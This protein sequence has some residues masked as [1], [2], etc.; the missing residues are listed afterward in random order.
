MAQRFPDDDDAFLAALSFVDEFSFDTESNP[1]TDHLLKPSESLKPVKWDLNEA[2][3]RRRRQ[4]NE[5]KKLLRRAGVYADPNRARSERRQEIARLREQLEQLQLDAQ[6]LR[7]RAGKRR[8][9]AEELS[10]S[11]GLLPQVPAVWQ[12]MALR[13][14]QRKEEAERENI[15]LKLVLKR[16]QQVAQ[17]LGDLVRRRAFQVTKECTDLTTQPRFRHHVVNVLD[18]D[19][20]MEDFR[21]L[22]LG[23]EAAYHEMEDVFAANGLSGSELSPLDIHLREGVDRRYIECFSH[24]VLPFELRATTAAVWEHFKGVEKHFGGG[25]IYT[26][27][28]K[29]LAEPYTV[30]ENFTKELYSNTSR[31]DI[32][33]KQVV[34]RYVEH[35]H[36]VVVWLAHVAPTN[37]AQDAPRT[38]VYSTWLH[39]HDTIPGCRSRGVGIAAMFDHFFRP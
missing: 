33:V 31:A 28:A 4:V 21:L 29:D 20:D 13:Q 12:D 1:N 25:D 38:D 8:P 16:Q 39:R 19:G 7:G 15:Q 14:R 18:V 34:R 3:Q 36:D 30:I 32:K 26:K 2:K 11:L 22:I 5:R 37:Q 6:V 35:D 23:L 9:S 27:A 17:T 10:T 24:K